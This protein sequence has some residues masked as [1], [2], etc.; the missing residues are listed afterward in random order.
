MM[1]NTG[2]LD[3]INA[4]RAAAVE[5][6]RPVCML[7]GLLQKEPGVSPSQSKQYGVRI[8]EPI[9]DAMGIDHLCIEGP[10]DVARLAPAIDRAYAESRPFAALI[11]RRVAP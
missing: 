8:V 7:V 10:E 4:L 5:Y 11:G 3:S 2:L 1:Q 6:Q 9:L